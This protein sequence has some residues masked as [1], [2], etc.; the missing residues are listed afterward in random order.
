MADFREWYVSTLLP[1]WLLGPMGQGFGLALAQVKDLVKDAAKEAVKARFPL[2]GPAD[3]LPS[4]AADRNL[5]RGAQTENAFRIYLTQAFD[6]WAKG[7]TKEGIEEA[8]DLLGYAT[9]TVYDAHTIDLGPG[10]TTDSAWARFIVVLADHPWTSDGTWDDPGT[11]DDG[12]TW[13]SDAP[14]DAVDAILRQVKRWKGAHSQCLFVV[15]P[16]GDA[17]IWDLPLDGT[18]G[19]PGVWDEGENV[20]Y[21]PVVD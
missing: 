16:F 15:V 3:A 12:G 10:P 1:T 7:G 14:K 9:A 8:V 19:D 17:E 11:W 6:L 5:E 13:D 4:I 2:L 20:A 21:W 18:W